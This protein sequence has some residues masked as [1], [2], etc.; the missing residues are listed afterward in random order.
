MQLAV[1]CQQA[2]ARNRQPKFHQPVCVSVN[3][4]VCVSV[5]MCD[6]ATRSGIATQKQERTVT[7]P[8]AAGSLTAWKSLQGSGRNK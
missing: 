8:C 1:G 4:P 3:Q 5:N 2:C 7:R 6:G